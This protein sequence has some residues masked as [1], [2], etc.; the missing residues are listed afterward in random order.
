MSKRYMNGMKAISLGLVPGH[1][2][3]CAHM[4]GSRGRQASYGDLDPNVLLA[5]SISCIL[6]HIHAP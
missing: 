3:S 6:V 2:I 1:D 4:A 5:L